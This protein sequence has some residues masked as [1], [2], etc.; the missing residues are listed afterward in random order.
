MNHALRRSMGLRLLLTAR[1]RPVNRYR[2]V[3]NPP[4][5]PWPPYLLAP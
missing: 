2:W 5:L 4:P 1:I 3:L